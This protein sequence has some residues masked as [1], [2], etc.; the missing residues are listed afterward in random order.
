MRRVILLSGTPALSRP[1]E[2]Y[3]QLSVIDE[4]FFGNFIEFSKRYCDGKEGPFGWDSSGKSNL[5]ELEVILGKK[6]MI[7]RTKTEVLTSLPEKSREIIKLDVGLNRLSENERL[8][9]SQMVNN[10]V[11]KKAQDKHMAL[12]ALFA[13]SAKIKIP[14]VR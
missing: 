4:K 1:N 13:E 2:L 6:F 11:G 5:S 7:R 10:Y 8:C 3:C 9:L 12:L 14:S